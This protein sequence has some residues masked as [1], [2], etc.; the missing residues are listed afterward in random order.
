M[1]LT[2]L[3]CALL[4]VF[5]MAQTGNGGQSAENNFGKLEYVGYSSGQYVLNVTNKQSCT[6]STRFE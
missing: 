3:I 6:V 4:P 2:I 5:S 1:K